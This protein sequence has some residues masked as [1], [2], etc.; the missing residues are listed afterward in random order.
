MITLN[1]IQGNPEWHQHRATHFNASDAPS[2]LGVSPYKTRAQLLREVATGVTAEVDAGTQRRFDDGHRFEALAR[3]LAEKI[4]GEELFPCTG[5]EGK[6]SASFDGL[7]MAGDTAFE[8]KTLNDELRTAIKGC[9]EYGADLPEHYRV[10]MEQQFLVSGA[11]RVLFMASRWDGNALMEEQHCWYVP[12]PKLRAR[13]IAGWKQFEA[14]ATAYVPSAVEAPAAIG[15]VPDQ[16]P[17]LHI[18]L[19][20]MVTA[21]NLAEYKDHAIAVFRDINTDLQ[22]DQDFADAEKAVKFCGDI[23]TRLSA[24]KDHAL[25]QTADIDALFRAIDSIKEEARSKRLELEKLVKARKEARRSEIAYAGRDAVTAHYDAINA[26]MAEHAITAPATIGA[27]L[28]AAIKGKRTISSI[29]DAV[30]SVVAQH[31][32]AASQRADQVR[33]S[34]AVMTELAAGHETLFA[35]R[36]ALCAS[37]APEDLR[38]LI[39][40]RIAEHEAKEKAKI[41]AAREQIRIEEAAKLKAEQ[42]TKDAKALQE[43]QQSAPEPVATVVAPVASPATVARKVY[44]S[45]EFKPT[46]DDIVQTISSAYSVTTVV[47]I[48]WLRKIDLDALA[49]AA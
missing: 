17:A 26:T 37:K 15:K 32:I 24:A 46:D 8:H 10:Q 3:P 4:I 38:N 9:I 43:A 33:A 34:V 47:V 39:A 49:K 42:D 21:S 28:N 16:L 29:Q 41:E 7:T 36:V 1:L 48:G 30:D 25:S 40:A 2:M 11:E 12:D 23:E 6:L 13:I 45:R 44:S 20:G 14:D 5:S 27:D 18:E 35:D 31:K 22:T 19:T